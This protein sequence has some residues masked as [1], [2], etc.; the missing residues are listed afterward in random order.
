LPFGDGADVNVGITNE[1]GG[2]EVIHGDQFAGRWESGDVERDG[3]SRM[4]RRK[5]LMQIARGEYRWPS[6]VLNGVSGDEN[7]LRGPGLV[8]SEGARRLVGRLL[9]RDPVRRAAI[10][11]LWN[12]EWMLG[13]GHGLEG[14][15]VDWEA[16]DNVVRREVV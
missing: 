15:L 13:G 7:E 2:R 4:Q 16:V 14:K 6:D 10:E 1:V 12:D 3:E 5:W 11:E 9:V 8:K